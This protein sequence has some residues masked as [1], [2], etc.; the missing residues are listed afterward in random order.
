MVSIEDQEAIII[1]LIYFSGSFV[2][3]PCRHAIAGSAKTQ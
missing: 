2:F 3:V 1:I